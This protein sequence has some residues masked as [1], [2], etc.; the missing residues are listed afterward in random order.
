M[1]TAVDTNVLLDVF[2]AAHIL[3]RSPQQH[4]GQCDRLLTRDRGF[5]RSNFDGLDVVD[6]TQSP[7]QRP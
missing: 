7:A 1:I 2:G 5:Y 6:P 3:V 4:C